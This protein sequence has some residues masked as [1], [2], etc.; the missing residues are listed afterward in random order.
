MSVIV[1]ETSGLKKSENSTT[2]SGKTEG[3]K[4]RPPVNKRA[5]KHNFSRSGS[6]RNKHRI[7]LL[8][9]IEAMAGYG[10]G[11]NDS[12][13]WRIRHFGHYDLQSVSVDRIEYQTNKGDTHHRLKKHTGAS[14]ALL[15]HQEVNGVDS[16]VENGAGNNLVAPCPS[17][18]NE[19]GGNWVLKDSPLRKLKE[20]LS[21]EKKMRV[22]SR[23]CAV[24]DGT[25]ASDMKYDTCQLFTVQSGITYPLEYF[26]FGACYY[27]DYFY[28]K[29]RQS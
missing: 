10:K 29:G 9:E 13:F 12:R 21:Q 3:E 19:V 11:R 14:A 23:E 7:K 8:Q 17:F 15:N 6:F 18:T 1:Q 27:R 24:L 20:V 28:G 5:N 26:D 16:N 2:T 4:E 22:Y 25:F